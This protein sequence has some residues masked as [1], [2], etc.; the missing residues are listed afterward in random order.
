MVGCERQGV[1]RVGWLIRESGESEGGKKRDK[2]EKQN[3]ACGDSKEKNDVN[4]HEKGV[5]AI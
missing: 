5:K 2:N 4:R 1:E 3:H